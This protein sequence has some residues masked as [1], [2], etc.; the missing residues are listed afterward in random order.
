MCA[1]RHRPA[2][3]PGCSTN[4]G[5]VHAEPL[6]P[7]PSHP[8]TQL[9]SKPPHRS[10]W[11]DPLGLARLPSQPRS[12]PSSLAALC[13][14]WTTTTM[15]ARSSMATLTVRR[16]Q[17]GGGGCLKG[18]GGRSVCGSAAP[19]AAA[20]PPL[21]S[22]SCRCRSVR[23]D[24]TSPITAA[25]ACL[26]PRRHAPPNCRCLRPT[27]CALPVDP[28][29]NDFEALLRVGPA[30][31]TLLVYLLSL[32]PSMVPRLQTPAS[33]TTRRCWPTSRT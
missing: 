13:C 7:P 18:G 2:G 21:A 26:H 9:L 11:Q 29:I 16:S 17:R 23:L 19:A 1:Q 31:C 24:V 14:Q 27:Y 5:A 28:C 30:C 33:P 8:L 20:T 32:W 3:A 10:A 22:Q 6:P 15:A 12:S 4:N 25:A